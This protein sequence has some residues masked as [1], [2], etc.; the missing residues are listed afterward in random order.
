MTPRVLPAPEGPPKLGATQTRHPTPGHRVTGGPSSH[1]SK[2][3]LRHCGAP[4]DDPRLYGPRPVAPAAAAFRAPSRSHKG[5]ASG[6]GR[7]CLRPTPAPPAQRPQGYIFCFS[8]LYSTSTSWMTF[9]CRNL[10]RSWISLRT[11]TGMSRPTSEQ[12]WCLVCPDR[13]TP[14]AWEEERA[15]RPGAVQRTHRAPMRMGAGR[16]S[17][18]LL[19]PLRPRS[20]SRG[21]NRGSP[22]SASTGTTPSGSFLNIL[23]EQSSRMRDHRAQHRDGRSS[24]ERAPSMCHGRGS[25]PQATQHPVRASPEEQSPRHRAI[26]GPAP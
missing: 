10:L 3:G 8:S 19:L 14:S 17:R 15:C 4:A 21:S 20:P 26:A 16:A 25:A 5:A 2:G 22:E 24:A 11:K 18:A 1:T 6:S 12:G 13:P 23:M 7:R 9:L